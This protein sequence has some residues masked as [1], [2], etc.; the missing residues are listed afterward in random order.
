MGLHLVTAPTSEPITTAAAKLHLRVDHS[1]DDDLI[2]TL[3][4][5]ARQVV[6]T[7]TGRKCI[8]QTWDLK[9][10]SFP[11]GAI[12][13]PFPPVTSITSVSY[14]DANGTTQTWSSA[15]YTTDVPPGADSAP[16]RIYPI[17]SE[18]YP[19]IRS[20]RNAV[21][22]RFVCG[23]TST[24]VPAG[25]LAAMKLLIGNWYANRESQ[26]VGTIAVELKDALQ[27]LTWQHKAFTEGAYA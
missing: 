16:A 7:G 17:Y 12:V 11:C 9:L 22:V 5:A 18:S 14:V 26:V 1:L 20:Q 24:T 25:M 8:T 2:D 6:E 3:C 10:D 4:S 21:T 27:T 23:F 13:L 19:T 15:L